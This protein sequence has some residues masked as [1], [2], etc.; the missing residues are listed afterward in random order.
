LTEGDT[1][2]RVSYSAVNYKDGLAVT[3]K[4]PVFR[5]FP[6]VPGIDLVG[7]VEATHT[8]ARGSAKRWF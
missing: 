1:L 6:M 7:I 2:V 8:P 3:N 5:R 4:A